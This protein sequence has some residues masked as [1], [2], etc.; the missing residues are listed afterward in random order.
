MLC[1]NLAE[2][3]LCFLGVPALCNSGLRLTIDE[4]A[5]REMKVGLLILEDSKEK[6]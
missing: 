2:L 1:V 3:E 4:F 5:A 6:L